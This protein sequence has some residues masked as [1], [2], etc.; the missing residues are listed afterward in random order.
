MSRCN[1]Q[2]PHRQLANHHI[3]FVHL[4]ALGA[5]VRS[6][7][8]LAA[9]Q[10]KYPQSHI[11]WVTDPLAAKLLRG[12][13]RIHRVLTTE[14]PDLLK[15]SALH[16]DVALNI[17]KSLE[18]GGVLAQASFDQLYGFEIDAQTGAI[19]PANAGAEELWRL[20]LDNDLK[21]HVNQKPETQLMVEALELGFFQ[22]D[23]YDLPLTSEELAEAAR[24][25][26]QW[27]SAQ[28]PVFGLNT[29]CSDVIPMKKWT[30]AFHRQVIQSLFQ[31]GFRN[32]VLLGGPEDTSRNR[33]IAQ[34]LPVV[35]SSTQSGLR[36]GL[37]S[38][39]AC[40]LIVTGDSLGLHMAIA[41]RKF[42]VAWFGPTCAH[43]I[44]L[45]DRGVAL[46]S[47]LAC[48]PCWRR[49]CHNPSMCYDQVEVREVLQAVQKGV[50]CI[51][52]TQEPRQDPL[53]IPI[54]L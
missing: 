7:S 19:L 39:E 3:L 46:R 26:V 30:V 34:G 32:I 38:V 16:F 22:R 18:A 42:S 35:Q 4:G 43:E 45:Y 8:L 29:G 1:P 50:Q 17:D 25:R 24:R 20:G 44:D 9:I 12:H 36:D 27:Q 11:T 40:D 47:Q 23:E 51:Q 2:C 13:P 33:E 14:A 21:F 49:S 48:S 37:I 41:R 52:A 28:G 10:R 5:V 54:E 6:T 53:R 15:L 31:E